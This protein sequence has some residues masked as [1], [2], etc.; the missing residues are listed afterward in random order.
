M[1]SAIVKERIEELARE[2]YEGYGSMSDIR[3]TIATAVNEA[4][5]MAANVS[6]QQC[7]PNEISRDRCTEA[8]RK[9]KCS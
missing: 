7:F 2:L 8:I 9:L 1:Q 3:K 5:E 6:E 4:L